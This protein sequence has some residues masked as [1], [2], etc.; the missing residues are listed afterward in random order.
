MTSVQRANPSLA[1]PACWA[2]PGPPGGAARASRLRGAA[3]IR[4][5]AVFTEQPATENYQGE[6]GDKELKSTR[7]LCY[8]KP[9]QMERLHGRN[10]EALQS[11]ALTEFPGNSLHQ[12]TALWISCLRHTGWSSPQMTEAPNII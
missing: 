2:R 8:K 9:S 4:R 11:T 10:T 12:L 1:T 3:A 7:Q 5:S 6:V